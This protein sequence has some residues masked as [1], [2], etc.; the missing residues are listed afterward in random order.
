MPAKECENGKW[1]WGTYGECIYNSK[2]EAEEDNKDYRSIEDIDLT[3][4]KE[5]IAEAKQGLEWRE[6]FGRGGTE[7]G[8]KT[9]NMIID[10]DLTVERI[11][12]MFAF[13][14]RHQVDKEA[15]GYNSGEDG[16]PS[17]GRIAIA[18]W[19]GDPG[20]AWSEDKRDEIKKEE[21]NEEEREL[22]DRIKKALE[23]KREEHNEE[24]KEMDLDWDGRVSLKDLETVFDRGIGAYN[25][26]PE[27]VRPS[28]KN[29]ETWAL[30]RVNSFLYAMKKGKFRGGNHDTDLLPKNHPVR[31]ELDKEEKMKKRELVGTMITD[32]IELP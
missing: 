21:E 31:I 4:T 25:T 13:H 5:M 23:N 6:E 29:P 20:F 32:G 2:E 19:G 12:K 7:V 27:S 24:I 8:V 10:N 11:K 15:E 9:A 16:F 14:S 30:A 3:P 22:S 17:A 26:N 18:L 28:V 1:K